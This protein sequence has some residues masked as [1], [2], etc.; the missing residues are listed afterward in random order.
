[1]NSVFDIK[2]LLLT[3]ASVII[4]YLIIE[5]IVRAEQRI[6]AAA[7]FTLDNPKA[8]KVNFWIAFLIPSIILF[9]IMSH[10]IMFGWN[11]F[12]PMIVPNISQINLY[13]SMVITVMTS[14]IRFSVN[15]HHLTYRLDH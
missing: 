12:S 13:R 9:L 7:L 10:I 14:I 6:Y 5:F 11:H 15:N 1:M 2:I 8:S 3:I 4:L